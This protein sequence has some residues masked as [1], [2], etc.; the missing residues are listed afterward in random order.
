MAQDGLGVL[1]TQWTA[2][3]QYEVSGAHRTPGEK[4][5]ERCQADS[6]KCRDRAEGT[7]RSGPGTP[8]VSGD[9]WGCKGDRQP[10]RIP[11]PRREQEKGEPRQQ[12]RPGQRERRM[13][14]SSG[15]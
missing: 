7:G 15:V 9:P 13:G 14:I 11:E 6:C 4:L 1:V 10:G 2:C 5:L 12:R 3:T 8:L